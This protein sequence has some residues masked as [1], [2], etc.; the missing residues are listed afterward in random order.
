MNRFFIWRPQCF[1]LHSSDVIVTDTAIPD[2]LTS[3]LLQH[4][5]NCG[6]QYCDTWWNDLTDTATPD[7][8]PSPILRYLMNWPHPYW[9]T[10]WIAVSNIVIPDE[11]TSQI[12]RHTM[13]CR[14]QYCDTWWIDL[15][16]TATPEK[17]PSPQELTKLSFTHRKLWLM[18]RRGTILCT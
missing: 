2:E 17:L 13:N 12:L 4:R 9:D 11:L 8:L 16:N 7:E 6:L 1:N 10:R 14:H 3:P 15:T 5:M 18:K